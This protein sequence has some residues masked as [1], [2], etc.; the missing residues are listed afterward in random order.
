MPDAKEQPEQN[1]YCIHGIMAPLIP[2]YIP[3]FSV[4]RILLNAQGYRAS[5][6]LKWF[7]QDLPIQQYNFDLVVDD[8][9]G[10]TVDRD[11]SW[12]QFR[13]NIINPEQKGSESI[14]NAALFM[15]RLE[16]MFKN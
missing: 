6:Y 2:F 11:A 14:A 5:N 3:E 10:L 8:G 7:L 16:G 1:H 9:N 4:I 13:I 12:K 15:E